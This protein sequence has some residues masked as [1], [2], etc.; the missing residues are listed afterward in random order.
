MLIQYVFACFSSSFP[1]RAC[2]AHA[3]CA[4][5]CVRA[6]PSQ[7][8]HRIPTAILRPACCVAG[9]FF[10]FSCKTRGISALNGEEMTE[11]PTFR[12]PKRT[13]YDKE[14]GACS[15]PQF[16]SYGCTPPSRLFGLLTP[17]SS[18]AIKHHAMQVQHLA[19]SPSG[20]SSPMS[21]SE[22]RRGRPRAESLNNLIMQGSTSPSSIKCTYCNRVFPREKSLQ[23][24]LRTHTG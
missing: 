6:R 20:H 24:H 13:H 15:S 11:R 21:P 8:V 10:V 23:A 5:E 16:A 18:P 12:T 3:R 22:T 17:D 2:A 7:P 14:N 1:S 9:C 4:T 19:M